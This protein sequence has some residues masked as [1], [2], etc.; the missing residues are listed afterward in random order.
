M[1]IGKYRRVAFSMATGSLLLIGFLLLLGAE[2]RP[3]RASPGVLFIAPSGSGT[4]CTQASPCAL[5]AALSKAQDGDTLYLAQGTYTGTG[6]AVISTTKSI[7]L[8]GG[9]NGAAGGPVV[10]DP[11]LYPSILDGERARRVVYIQGP[12]T[13]TLDGLTIAHGAIFSATAPPWHGA[14]LYARD[15][16]LTLRQTRFYSNVIDVYEVANSRAYGSGAMAEGGTV[17]VEGSS[18]QSNGAWAS[19]MSV[20]GGLALS[21]TVSAT[22]VDTLFQNN[23][24]WNASGLYFLGA[25][26]DRSPFTLRNSTFTGNGQGRSLG[27]AF[28]GYA[29]AVEVGKAKAYLERNVFVGNYAGNDYGAMRVS[30]SELILARNLISGNQSYRTPGLYIQ[31]VAPFTLTNN[32]IVQNRALDA[33][34]DYPAVWVEGSTG[35]FLHN[36]IARNTSRYG[37]QVIGAGMAVTLTNTIL[38][39]HTV[40]ITVGAGSTVTLRSTLWGSGPWANGA[41]WGGNGVI[42]TGTVNIWGDPRFVNPAAGDYHL[43]LGSAAIDRGV[44]AGVTTDIDGERRP[45][46]AGYDIGAD[47]FVPRTYLPLVAKKR[48]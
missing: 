33:R 25:S 15:A 24:A 17:T 48:P 32:M 2:P 26:G 20:G 46:G 1:K 18:F 29:G 43:G 42:L 47:E 14:G 27:P 40:G 16:S 6:A 9:W 37:V 31:N 21:G 30:A 7:T 11:V 28:G 19:K 38:V 34:L 10:R 22:V 45:F 12:L 44:N 4:A 35:Q 5:S 23:D 13:I 36:T 8:Y 3:A 41:D 39:S